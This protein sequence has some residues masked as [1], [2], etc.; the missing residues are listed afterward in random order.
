MLPTKYRSFSYFCLGGG[1]G[2]GYMITAWVVYAFPNWRW[3]M[4]F[5]SFIGVIYIPYYW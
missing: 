3:F 4:R 1:F 5:I 2:V